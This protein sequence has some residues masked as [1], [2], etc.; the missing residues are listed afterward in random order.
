MT[1]HP[2]P[3]SSAPLPRENPWASQT[4]RV[5]EVAALAARQLGVLH[6]AQLRD[7]GVSHGRVEH[8]IDVGRWVAAAPDVVAAQNAGLTRSQRM[9]LGVLHGG[10]R[11]TLTHATACEVGGLSWTGDEAVHVLTPKGDL[12]SALPGIRFH[13]TRRSYD[14]WVRVDGDGLPC[15]D[16]E[17][18]VLLTSER[19]RHVRR[20]VGRIA[21]A[22]QQQLTTADRLLRASTTIRKLRHGQLFRQSLGDIAG[23]AQSFAEIDI[24]TLCREAG[25][26]P[27][28]RQEVRRDKDGRRR[29][30]DCTWRLPSGRCVVL[31]IDGSFHM[32]VGNWWRDLRRQRSLVEWNQRRRPLCQRRD[33][34]CSTRESS[35]TC[36]TS[37]SPIR[38][39]LPASTHPRSQTNR[40]G[41]SPGPASARTRR[42]RR[43]GRG[44]P[45]PGRPRPRDPPGASTRSR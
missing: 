29:Y 17:H 44:S 9:W 1:R 13:Q 21:A 27:P 28:D 18:A 24:G 7:L 36:G 38:L 4:N 32:Q 31:E 39:R 20:A 41:V 40:V 8:E 23:G 34:A 12:A 5:P 11:A 19:D 15:L 3:D 42:T 10:P 45:R 30:L 33:P 2:H 37:A 26:A 6:R 35:R 14:G 22:V 25:L 43:D 16:I